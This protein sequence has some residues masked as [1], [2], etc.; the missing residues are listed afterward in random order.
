MALWILAANR[1]PEAY[2]QP[3]VFDARLE[4]ARHLSFATGPHFCLGA[5]LARMEAR[6]FAQELLKHVK[7]IE[8]LS[9]PIRSDNGV[10]NTI[11]SLDARFT[12]Y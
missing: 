9:D 7:D 2:D 12:G 6:V 10:S 3:Q 1:D 4:R 11:V 8:L 5:R